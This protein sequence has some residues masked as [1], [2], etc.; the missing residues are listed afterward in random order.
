MFQQP[1]LLSLFDSSSPLTSA[2]GVVFS[3]ESKEG[4]AVVGEEARLTS[5]EDRF[6]H[7]AIPAEVLIH[8]MFKNAWKLSSVLDCGFVFERA[9]SVLGTRDDKR[10]PSKSKS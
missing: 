10:K 3:V 2:V 8:V 1:L 6:S 5:A 4:G 9:C 7:S